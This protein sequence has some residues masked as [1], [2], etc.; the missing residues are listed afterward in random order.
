LSSLL[1]YSMYLST[2]RIRMVSVKASSELPAQTTFDIQASEDAWHLDLARRMT[3][4]TC[5]R[6][7]TRP[8]RVGRG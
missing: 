8:V 1:F 3:T 6:V 7:C 4:D 5:T 2:A